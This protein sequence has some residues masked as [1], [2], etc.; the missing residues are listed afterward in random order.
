MK[1]YPHASAPERASA[2][3]LALPL[4]A[5]VVVVGGALALA[6]RNPGTWRS[7][8]TETVQGA[9]VRRGPLRIAVTTSGNLA[10]ADTVRLISGVEGRTTIL[11]LAPEGTHVAK[12]DVVCEL[13]ATTL[14]EKRIEQSIRVGN[15]EAELVKASQ[16]RAIQVSQ[17]RSD[18]DKAVRTIQFAEQDLQMFVEGERDVELETAQQAIDLAKEES[19]RAKDRLTW[20]TEL[21]A[22][23]FLTSTELEADRIAEH[24]ASVELQQAERELE[25]SQ[26]FRLPRR[27]TEL[28][29]AL[30]EARLE[31]ERVELQAAARLVDY[32][33]DVRSSTASLDLEREKL[34]RLQAQIEAARLR[35]PRDGYV[36][37][38]QRD[39]DDPPISEGAE[40]RQREEILAIPS[41]DGMKVEIKL[42]ESVLKQVAAGQRC[43]ISVDALRG[44]RL[45]GR[46][47]FVAML[48]DQN[49]R[50]SNPNL[51]VYRCEIAVVTPSEA[52]RPG[53]SCAVEILVEELADA[54]HV[55]VQAVFRD[56]KRNASFVVTDGRYERRDVTV[57]R[58]TDLWVE[59]LDGLSEGETV[60]LH[61]PPGFVEIPP[62]DEGE[63]KER[64]GEGEDS[65]GARGR[66][67]PRAA[68]GHGDGAEPRDA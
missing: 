20:S 14:V 4:V 63:G 36:V 7:S 47:E 17:N 1:T 32:E 60:L 49:S 48:P 59:I 15:A 45:E 12:G 8:G 50:W 34:A 39:N 65:G 58:Y 29:A 42:H 40:V 13:D 10:A 31:H 52:I 25:L 6:A 5:L 37:Y 64:D 56:G 11:S 43:T 68:D 35:A 16:A 9:T 62:D 41:S 23:G 44:L 55:P 21:N 30:E 53:M 33:S 26:R 61:P 66:D 67:E 2:G 22:K 18:L 27:E 57:G 3:R 51:R 54:L 28:R 46:V 19:Q 38:A 24:R